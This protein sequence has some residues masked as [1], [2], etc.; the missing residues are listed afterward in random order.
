MYQG[1]RRT[2]KVLSVND[3]RG[4]FKMRFDEFPT[5]QFDCSFSYKSAAWSYVDSS[6]PSS[7]TSITKPNNND[8][9]P[10]STISRK[11]KSLIKVKR[12]S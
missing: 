10:L 12:I 11:F 5:A 8:D 4:I 7:V 6:P 1:V 2:G 9:E 3:K